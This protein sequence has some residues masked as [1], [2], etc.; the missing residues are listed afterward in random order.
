MEGKIKYWWFSFIVGFL[1]VAAGVWYLVQPLP[2]FVAPVVLLAAA[3]LI[4]GILDIIFAVTNRKIPYGWGWLLTLAILS[5]IF[6]MVSILGSLLF[7][8]LTATFFWAALIAYGIFRVGLAAHLRSHYSDIK[9]F[10]RDIRELGKKI[11]E[12]IKDRID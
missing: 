5:V 10:R 2:A 6:S 7:G 11:E 9:D 3:F 4:S 8:C 12:K 1:A